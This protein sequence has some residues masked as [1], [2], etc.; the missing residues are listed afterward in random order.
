MDAQ[1]WIGFIL[2]VV[3]FLLVMGQS[4]K[5]RNAA[6]PKRKRRSKD[7]DIPEDGE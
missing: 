7:D 5:A 2:G 3:F 6:E 1:Q 4:D